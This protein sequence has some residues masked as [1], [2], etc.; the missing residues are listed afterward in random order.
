MGSRPAL[1][2]LLHAGGVGAGRAHGDDAH[3]AGGQLVALLLA[4]LPRV[5]H[6]ADVLRE[7]RSAA[8]RRD[9]GREGGG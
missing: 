1:A 9:R 6:S 7:W 4:G 3:K 8:T 2:A 5:V